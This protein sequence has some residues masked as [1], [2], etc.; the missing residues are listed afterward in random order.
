MRKLAER[1][2]RSSMDFMQ[3]LDFESSNLLN[4]FLLM[5]PNKQIPL[6][7]LSYQLQLNPKT[8]VRYIKKLQRLVHRFDLKDQLTIKNTIKAHVCLEYKQII[9]LEHFRI[10][11]LSNIPEIVFLKAAIEAKE[12]RTKELAEQLSMSESNL[13]KRVKKIHDWLQENHIQLKRG[14][15]EL[16]GEEAKLRMF[17]FHFYEFVYRSSKPS[18]LMVDRK[19]LQQTTDHVYSFFQLHLNELQKSSL[20]RLIQV[21]L[22]R[23]LNGKLIKIK[24]EWNEYLS[25]SH[26]FPMFYQSFYLSKPAKSISREELAFLFLIVQ[27]KYLSYFNLHKQS[28][29]IYEHYCNRTSCYLK[30]LAA[31]TKFKQVFWEH[32]V[33]YSKESIAA[34]L[35]FHLYHEIVIES[36]FE[37]IPKQL[38][39][40]EQYPIFSRKLEKCL[41]ELKIESN[42]Y[43]Q[44]PEKSLFYR[45]FLIFTSLISPVSC[46]RKIFI[47][48]MTDFPLEKEVDLGKRILQFFAHKYNIEVIYARRISSFL[49]SD[50]ILVTRIDPVFYKEHAKKIL[51]IEAEELSAIFETLEELLSKT[52]Y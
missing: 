29:F 50:I 14:S 13:R 36:L 4:L 44:I 2:R 34:L 46:E 38:K 11:Y 30:T 52:K 45:Y 22:W 5:T 47:C 6:E 24:K 33:T 25:Q 51:L 18:F 40:K 42:G 20:S 1:K 39:M 41:Y 10:R 35:G 31:V 16:I 48:L 26:Y 9:S 28:G 37:Q 32:T 12:I 23:F 8:I 49:Y 27:A 17:I 15:Y 7:E 3:L 19:L 21:F 43:K